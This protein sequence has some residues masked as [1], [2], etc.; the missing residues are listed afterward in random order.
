MT[1]ENC[2]YK[3][4][5]PFIHKLGYHTQGHIRGYMPFVQV[6]RW[7]PPNK[8]KMG[9]RTFFPRRGSHPRLQVIKLLASLT[10]STQ[11]FVSPHPTFGET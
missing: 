3:S 9:T 6:V 10:L 1:R 7:N 2:I 11:N 5:H 8:N 4:K